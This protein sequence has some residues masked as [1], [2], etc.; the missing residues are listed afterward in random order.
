MSLEFACVCFYWESV[1]YYLYETSFVFC[2]YIAGFE[3]FTDDLSAAGFSYEEVSSFCGCVRFC[4]GVVFS[5]RGE[6]VEM[7]TEDVFE[8]FSFGFPDVSL[9]N[10]VS[11]FG[12]GFSSWEVPCPPF[13][14]PSV[15]GFFEFSSP[16]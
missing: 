2:S 5:E 14:S 1:G 8:S 12:G 9:K 4:I 3:V 15:D 11:F 16:S 10:S 7:T 13:Y 6:C